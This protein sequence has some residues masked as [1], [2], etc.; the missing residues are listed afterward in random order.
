[1]KEDQSLKALK[2][3]GSF[4]GA[5]Y[6][7]DCVALTNCCL[8]GLGV[9]GLANHLTSSHEGVELVGAVLVPACRGRPAL[10]VAAPCFRP[11]AVGG[12]VSVRRSGDG[13]LTSS[14]RDRMSQN[15][16]CP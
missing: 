14:E 1:M 6:Q 15:Q 4:D 9:S 2:S 10:L 5:V 7:N 12:C 3:K 11:L 8:D 13:Q 16:P